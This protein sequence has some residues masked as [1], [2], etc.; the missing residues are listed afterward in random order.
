MAIKNFKDYHEFSFLHAKYKF[1]SKVKINPNKF[2]SFVRKYKTIN[3]VPDTVNCHGV[4][5]SDK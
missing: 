2:W 1:I 3:T 5:S 4:V